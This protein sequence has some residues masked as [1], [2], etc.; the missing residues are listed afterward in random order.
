MRENPPSRSLSGR[1]LSWL[2]GFVVVSAAYLYTFPQANIFYAGVV[3]LHAVGGVLAAI[4]LIPTLLRLLRSGTWLARAGWPLM[5][6]GLLNGRTSPMA[7]GCHL[8]H[9]FPVPIGSPP[10]QVLLEQFQHERDGV[11]IKGIL[12]V[13]V[14]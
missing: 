10:Y 9:G 8:L 3:L 12:R 14:Q 5:F 7:G 4:L 1:A 11:T 6:V 2:I 13:R